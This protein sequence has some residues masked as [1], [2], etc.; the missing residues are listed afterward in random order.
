[1]KFKDWLKMEILLEDGLWPV[2]ALITTFVT[3]I[4]ANVIVACQKF[5]SNKKAKTEKIKR[6]MEIGFDYKTALDLTN[7]LLALGKDLD[8]FNKKHRSKSCTNTAE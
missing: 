6:L 5:M 8:E 3:F 4:I 7:R 1:M 2:M